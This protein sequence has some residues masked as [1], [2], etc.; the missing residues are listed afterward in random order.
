MR[1]D[2]LCRRRAVMS[3]CSAVPP[4]WLATADRPLALGGQVGAHDVGAVARQH[5]AIAAPMPWAAPV[6]TATRPSNGRSQSVDPVG[7]G[8]AATATT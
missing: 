3:T 2:A 6:T 8:C 4:T 7:P 5:A 1:R